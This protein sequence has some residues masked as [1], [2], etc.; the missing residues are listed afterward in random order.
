MKK[1]WYKIR[2]GVIMDSAHEYLV[3]RFNSIEQIHVKHE[4]LLWQGFQPESDFVWF[5][6]NAKR[7]Y[8]KSL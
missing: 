6:G 3:V 1:L 4:I 8:K 7:V 2:Y 5:L